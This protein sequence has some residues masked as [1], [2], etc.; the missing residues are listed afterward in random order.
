MCNSHSHDDSNTCL[1]GSE[2]PM[3]TQTALIHLL[4][5]LH[6]GH[7]RG[8]RQQLDIFQSI[9]LLNGVLPNR[10]SQAT[11]HLGPKID[12]C[13]WVK[14]ESG[15]DDSCSCINIIQS[16]LWAFPKLAWTRRAKDN[17]LPLHIA[18]LI[19]NISLA[20]ILAAAVSINFQHQG[21]F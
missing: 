5:C 18:A 13:S 14:E 3:P 12:D 20:T 15:C 16:L 11:C 2:R 10:N 7:D 8:F 6:S 21:A 4:E 17:A 19:G 1:Y 9:L